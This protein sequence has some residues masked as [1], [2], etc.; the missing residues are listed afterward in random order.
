[1][2]P[3]HKCFP[4]ESKTPTLTP[5]FEISAVTKNVI[6]LNIIHSVIDPRDTYVVIHL[7][8]IKDS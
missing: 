3:S 6:I 5:N 7:T 2:M 1:M 4:R 8:S